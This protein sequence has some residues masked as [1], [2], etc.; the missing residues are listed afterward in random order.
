MAYGIKYELYFSDNAKRK[1]KLEILEKGYTGDV[2]PIVGTGNPVEIEWDAD[3]DI[4]KPIIGSRCK[5]SFFVTDTTIYDDFYKSDERQYKVKLLHY[6]S[7]NSEISDGDGVWSLLDVT[8]NE[9]VLGAGIYYEPIWEGFIVVDRFQEAI[10]TPPYQIQLEAID[11]LGTLE[12][13]DAPFSS[14][15]ESNSETLFYYLKEILKLTGHT[16]D[17]YIANGIRKAT[18]PPDDQ[19][20]FHDITINEY[21]LF[22]NGLALRNAKDVLEQIL[23]ITNSRIFQS[24][25]RWYV[26]S[27]SNLIDN[28]IDTTGVIDEIAESGDDNTDDPPEDV[29]TAI[30]TSPSIDIIGN[31]SA[32]TAGS[33]FF[34]ISNVGTAIASYEWTLPDGS[35]NSNPQ[36][37]FPAVISDNGATVECTV[38]DADG[39]TDSDSVTITVTQY[40]PPPA[41]PEAIEE[42]YT[43]KFNVLTNL[44]NAY[45]N[46][47]T[48]TFNF[49]ES[50]VGDA[51]TF[52][53]NVYSLTGEFDSTSQ[54]TTTTVT[55]GYT[56]SKTLV[57]E[58][59]RV[60]VSGN[61]PSSSATEN[62][63]LAGQADVQK[64]TTTYTRAGTVQNSS[65]SLNPTTLSVSGAQDKPYEMTIT[66]TAATDYEWRGAQDLTILQSSRVPS[67]LD[68]TVT[69]TKTS[70][71]TLVVKITGAQG[72]QDQ[73]A[74]FT[75]TGTPVYA[76]D[77]TTVT[78][79]PSGLN[80]VTPA[81]GYINVSVSGADG[82]F[83]IVSLAEWITV[84]TELGNPST[85]D[86]VVSFSPNNTT[87][88]RRSAVQFKAYASNTILAT[89]TLNQQSNI[90]AG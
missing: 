5:L 87:A 60:T 53:I 45:A 58:Y 69:V 83:S 23:K 25:G 37:S 10:I 11:G 76:A 57:A 28:T 19:T 34:S 70:D 20:I 50:Q 46:P 40:N 86:V 62:I 42:Q 88:Q 17:I 65:F 71:T 51:F 15:T 47:L 78:I 43:L 32:S 68:N 72:I 84:D 3:D 63:T 8:W 13:F 31:T 64:F 79:D 75:I 26:I 61:Y 90:S 39:N 85:T 59:I 66:Y 35:T 74:T 81:G 33:F 36:I 14:D 12:G 55:G 56:I 16:F 89:L 41:E 80:E 82:K 6:S 2:S 77:A 18:N 22:D 21:G 49:N 48:A 24:F 54:L 38:T 29:V 67:N 1:L 52:N 27:N 4:Y 73:S 7:F 9:D 44:V 30:Y